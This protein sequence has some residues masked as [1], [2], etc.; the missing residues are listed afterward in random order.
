MISAAQIKK[1]LKERGELLLIVLIVVVLIVVIVSSRFSATSSQSSYL[2]LS[3]RE[4]LRYDLTNAVR[5]ISGDSDA[6]V[7]VVWDETEQNQYTSS[8]IISVFNNTN[9]QN[10]YENSLK[11]SGIA[12]VCKNGSKAD[13]KVKI[14]YLLSNLLEISADKISVIGV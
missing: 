10:T 6:R 8:D 1:L 5:C 9:T 3:E 4:K 7:L 2:S 12:V 14:T 11:V 13:I